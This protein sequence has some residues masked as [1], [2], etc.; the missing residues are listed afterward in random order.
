MLPGGNQGAL[1]GTSMAT[2]HVTGVCSLF[3]EW[4]IVNNN[5]PF[6]YSAKLKATLLKSARRRN[7]VYYPNNLSGYGFLNLSTLE[8]EQIADINKGLEFQY[9][10]RKKK[11]NSNIMTK[12][13]FKLQNI[14]RQNNIPNGINILYGPGFE[15]SLNEIAPD[16]R[17]EKLSNEYGIVFITN[18][19]LN[20]LK[21]VLSIQSAIRTE[22]LVRMTMLGEITPGTEGGI[23]ANEEIGVNFFKN[24][25]NLPLNGRGVAIA[26]MGSGIDYL[27]PDFIYPDGTS[28]ILYLWDQTKE[29]TP[30][31]GFYIGTE[32]TRENINEAIRNN[33]GSLSVDEEGYGTMI[34]GICAGLGNVN[35]D[36]KGVAEGADLIVIKLGK[37]NGYYNNAMLNVAAQYAYKKALELNMPIIINNITGSN[38]LV[39]ISERTIS[40]QAF[41]TSGLCV[42]SAAGNEGNTQTHV[43]GK[44]QFR[45][46]IKYIDLEISEEEENLEIQIWIDVP[47]TA[48]VSIISPSGEESKELNVV[49]LSITS[50]IFDF[51][52]TIY[53]ITYIFPTTYSGQQQT[54]INLYNAKRGIWRIKLRGDYITN[55]IYHAYLPNKVF[56]NPGTKFEDTNPNYT[57]TFPATYSDEITVGAY[58]SINRG[59]WQGSSRGPTISGLQKPDLIAPGVNIIAPYPGGGYATITG[60]APAASY[61]CGCAAMFMQ[62]IYTD[63]NY[64]RKAFVQKIRTIFRAGAIREDNISYPNYSSGYGLLNMIKIMEIF[65]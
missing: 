17:F 3:H 47:D 23:N 10:N 21:R 60:T 41:F 8:L 4:G 20:T 34:S 51:E 52:S 16:F 24:N 13:N 11:L 2:P 56:I 44:L 48:I 7:N 37:T 54:I 1:T 59:L 12:S 43:S 63:N 28:K 30:P 50:G 5:D 33:D 42:I 53:N 36:Y 19:D 58:D 46:D 9:R 65:R 31:D 26:I 38:S 61:T 39:G 15:E 45:G 55:G 64:R 29:G 18:N 35:P 40:K 14:Y 25:P 27:H 22:P 57:I 49:D 6:L 62:Y 32:Y